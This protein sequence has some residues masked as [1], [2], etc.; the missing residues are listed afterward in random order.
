M[1]YA[2]AIREGAKPKAKRFDDFA[3]LREKLESYLPA[4]EIEPI[5]A[6]YEYSKKLAAKAAKVSG[7]KKR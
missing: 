3:S 1:E 5:S 7:A 6:A 2:E 4:D